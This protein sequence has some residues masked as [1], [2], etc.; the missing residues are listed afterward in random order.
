MWISRAKYMELVERIN[1]LEE[2]RRPIVFGAPEFS[3]RPDKFMPLPVHGPNIEGTPVTDSDLLCMIANHL[4]FTHTK[5]VPGGI[6][7]PLPPDPL[8]QKTIK[9]KRPHVFKP[10][11]KKRG[12]A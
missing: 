6:T 5:A 4:G 9:F 10:F 7:P 11:P 1:K 2:R 3:I 12:K 8:A